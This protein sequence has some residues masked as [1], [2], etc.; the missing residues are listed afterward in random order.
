MRRPTEEPGLVVRSAVAPH[1]DDDAQPDVAPHPHRFGVFL[2]AHPSA[3]VVGP[4][5]LTVAHAGKRKLPH[6]V[7]QGTNT[8]PANMHDADGPACPCDR[9]GTGL[10]LGDASI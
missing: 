10:A 4:D 5:P 6:R 1:G 8:G 3:S 2:A 9:C 7:P